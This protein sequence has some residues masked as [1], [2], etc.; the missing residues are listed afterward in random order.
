[1]VPC[2]TD[3]LICTDTQTYKKK[4]KVDIIVVIIIII[5]DMNFKSTVIDNLI[6][7]CSLALAVAGPPHALGHPAH[8]A[9]SPSLIGPLI[10]QKLLTQPQIP[11]RLAQRER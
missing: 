9:V 10:Q 8:V 11:Q 6:H 5:I 7:L 1:M 3:C 2:Y 4:P